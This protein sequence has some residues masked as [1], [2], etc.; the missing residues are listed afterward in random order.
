VRLANSPAGWLPS[1]VGSGRALDLEPK[2]PR[3]TSAELQ[4]ALGRDQEAA[5][6]G[7]LY[8]HLRELQAARLIT[9]RRRGEYELAA[10]AVIPILTILAAALHVATDPAVGAPVAIIQPE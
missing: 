2:Q 10:Q 1:R 4:E 3:R 5:T 9:Q 8:H 6:S 7:H